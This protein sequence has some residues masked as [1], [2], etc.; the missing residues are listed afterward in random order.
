[1][2][3]YFFLKLGCIL[4]P[5]MLLVGMVNYFVDP[6]HIF[7]SKNYVAGLAI[8]LSKGHNADNVSNYD[9]RLLQEQMIIR[10][11]RTPDIVALGSSRIMQ[12]SSDFF[13]GKTILNCGVS[14]ANVKDL[15]AITGL[16]DSMRRLP[17]EILLNADAGL[18]G[19]DQTEEWKSLEVYY[20][21]FMRQS[22]LPDAGN[23]FWQF[24]GSRQL[25]SIFSIEYMQAS[26]DFLFR[27][28][29]GKYIDIGTQKPVSGGRFADGSIAYDD[30]YMHGSARQRAQFELETGRKNGIPAPS[31]EQQDLLL[32][33]LDFLNKRG[34]SVSFYLLPY[35]P[36][37]YN[38]VNQYHDKAFEQYES[39]YRNL[40]QKRSLSII[41]SFN[42]AVYNISGTMFYDMY[43]CSKEAIG[44]IINK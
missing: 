5:A 14:H 42:P 7:F 29:T 35:N 1:M 8:I 4:F 17:S 30:A 33:L 26:M 28:H 37:L 43:H 9:E 38:A 13:P 22:G 23:H 6:A 32:A 36:D 24:A 11:K 10:L 25:T 44:K 20:H 16:L 15:I 21:Y 41:G 27:N 40:A 34:A 12:F 31:E 18:I 3:R 19:S 2:I 39:Y